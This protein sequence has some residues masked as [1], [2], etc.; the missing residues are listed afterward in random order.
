MTSLFALAI[1]YL[2]PQL[3]RIFEYPDERNTE[4]MLATL[5]VGLLIFAVILLPPMLFTHR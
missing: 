2:W 4:K 1:F 5:A 3:Y